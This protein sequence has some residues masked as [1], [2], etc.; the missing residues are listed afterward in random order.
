VEAERDKPGRRVL[1]GLAWNGKEVTLPT[2]ESIRKTVSLVVLIVMAVNVFGLGG[3]G[4]G[5]TKE[6]QAEQKKIIIEMLRTSSGLMAGVAAAPTN[7][8]PR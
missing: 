8:V 4:K 7:G 1:S 6:Q 5:M 3:C 2:W